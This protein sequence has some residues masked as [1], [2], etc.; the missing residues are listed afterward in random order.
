MLSRSAL[1][2][3]ALF[4]LGAAAAPKEESK[5]DRPRVVAVKSADLA[6]YAQVVAG[7]TS[8]TRAQV[9]ELLLEEG[10]EAKP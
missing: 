2:A 1:I 5:S 6:A 7:F 3:V 10:P 8:E 9:E 4:A